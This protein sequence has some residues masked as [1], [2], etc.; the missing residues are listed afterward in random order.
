MNVVRKQKETDLESELTVP[1]GRGR[2]RGGQGV[3]DGR[4]HTAV[5]NMENQQGPAGEH[6]ELCS[7]SRGSLDGRGVW[8]RM[9]TCVC[10]AES[11]CCPP[12]ITTTLLISYI[13]I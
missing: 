12:E 7:M 9:D 4:G 2:G 5:F 11:L 1:R 13:P 8:G 6:R 10:I 3:W